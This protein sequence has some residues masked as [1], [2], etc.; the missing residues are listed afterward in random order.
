MQ[1]RFDGL[2]QQGRAAN[3]IIVGINELKSSPRGKEDAMTFVDRQN[4]DTLKAFF[5]TTRP[6]N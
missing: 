6:S 4:N 3:K 1:M 5:G 2:R